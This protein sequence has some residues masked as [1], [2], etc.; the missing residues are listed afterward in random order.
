MLHQ[1]TIPQQ[2]RESKPPSGLQGIK[3]LVVE[4]IT[5]MREYITFVLEQEG[6][7]V[8]AVTSAAE[9]L[10]ALDQFQPEVLVSDIGMP[11][12]DGYM[13]LRQVRRRSPQQGGQTPAI[14]LTAYAREIDRQQA[15]AAGFQHHLAKP[16]E[17]D[18]LVK[19]ILNLL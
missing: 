4:D 2:V 19:V 6:A 8:V 16:V 10:T 15:L 5:D 12:M 7:T 11:E 14:A 3:V 18:E 9:A 1:S 13:L 17:L